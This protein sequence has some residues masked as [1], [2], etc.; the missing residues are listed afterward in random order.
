M[1]G[2]VDIEVFEFQYIY[3]LEIVVILINKLM[4]CKDKV[5]L[6]YLMVEEKYEVIVEDIKVCVECG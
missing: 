3:G 4:Q 5:D 6:I 2:I 1:I